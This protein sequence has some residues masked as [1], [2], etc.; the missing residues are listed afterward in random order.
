MSL[1]RPAFGVPGRIQ[2]P[3][4]RPRSMALVGLG[5][6]GAEVAERLGRE[7]L[8]AQGVRVF[9]ASRSVGE[10][11]LAAIKSNGDDLD[12]ALHEADMIFV[13]AR[14]GDDVGMVPVVSRI[15]RGRHA[16]VTAIYL[17]PTGAETGEDATLAGLRRGVE[18]LVVAS[19]ETY[20]AA[21]V[22]ALGAA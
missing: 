10:D 8:K 2:A 11:A 18:M 16:S 9:A 5:S 21:M 17:A 15:A 14:R 1:P 13:V 3:N 12:R 20:V 4:S 22:S 6:G 19:D 7:T